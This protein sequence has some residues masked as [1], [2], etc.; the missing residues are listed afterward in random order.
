[1]KLTK[2][3]LAGIFLLGMASCSSSSNGSQQ[4]DTAQPADSAAIVANDTVATA[5]A[6]DTVA[7]DHSANEELIRKVYN[8]FVFKY[9]ESSPKPYFT[10]KALKKLKKAYDYDCETGDCYG[11]WALRTGVEDG[12]GSSAIISITPEEDG[13]YLV[14]YKDMGKKGSTRIE[15]EDGKINDYK[16]VK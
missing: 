3:T 10:A 5:E 11:Y 4:A 1:M 2:I 8:K 16:R 6:A 13:W 15:I 7:V 9:S 12:N 14:S